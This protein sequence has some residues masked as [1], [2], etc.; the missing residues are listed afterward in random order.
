M[1]A[2]PGSGAPASGRRSSGGAVSSVPGLVRDLVSQFDRPL[3]FY[4]ELIQNAIDASTNRIDVVLSHDGERGLIRVMDDGEGMDERI[5]DDYLLVLFRSTKEGD[6]TKIGKFGIGFVSVFALQPQLVRVLT[7]K[8]GESWRLDFPS[9]QRYEKY[10]M[11][12]PRDGTVV[13]L[14]KAMTREEFDRL[15]EESAKT[16]RYWCKHSEC[17]IYFQVSG[18]DPE[19]RLLTEPFGLEDAS[20]T[21][22]EEGTDVA[23]GFS[24]EAKPFY[25]FYNRGLTLKEGQEAHFP[26]VRFKAKSRYLEHTLTRDNVML[27]ENYQKLM[28]ILKRLT[29]EQLP[30][31]LRVELGDLSGKLAALSAAAAAPGDI[32]A[33]APAPSP[34]D[35]LLEAWKRRVPYLQWLY[36]GTLARWK[37]SDWKIF[38]TLS[39]RTV[40]LREVRDA[41]SR[42]GGRLFYDAG[43]NRITWALEC[44][45]ALVLPAGPWIDCLSHWLKV[46]AAQ[47]S[48]EFIQPEVAKDAALPAP[49]KAFLDTL[50]WMDAQSGAKYRGIAAADLAY[51]G[52]SVGSR[53]FVIQKEPGLLSPAREQPVSSLL[54]FRRPKRWAL[55]HAG[56]PAVEKFVRLHSGRPGLA[57]FLC[58]KMMHLH[59]GE[60]PPDQESEYTNLAEKME[61]RLLGAA[62]K[63]DAK[64]A[65]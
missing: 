14:H 35:P 57:A 64:A 49:F 46:P 2:E 41:L 45:G 56:H 55:L 9:Y 38:P 54:W 58:L 53:V 30:E 59:D 32:P 24:E 20:L 27:D 34:A 48:Q 28:G 11:S 10:R 15:A 26:G 6:F 52:S 13:E 1:S 22:R 3:D 65:R 44:K 50:R 29:A 23:L 62:L 63:L 19:P 39:G 43:P 42:S 25:G 61:A 40:S 60:V 31:R 4:R 51:A 8:A 5:I 47:A 12:Q 16:I 7:G 21:F 37:R 18:R 33:G 36:L 17:R